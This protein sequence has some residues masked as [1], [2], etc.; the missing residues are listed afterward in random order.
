MSETSL[1]VSAARC[2]LCGGE[3]VGPRV[4]VCGHN[5]CTRCLADHLETEHSKA[6][7]QNLAGGDSPQ[8]DNS[9]TTESPSPPKKF[10]SAANCQLDGIHFPCPQTGCDRLLHIPNWDI[11]NFPLNSTLAS[12]SQLQ[13]EKQKMRDF[14]LPAAQHKSFEM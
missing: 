9:T 4:T 13:I 3:P 8:E 5:F 2:G 12:L 10:K 1:S 11:E 7:S 6:D 14:K